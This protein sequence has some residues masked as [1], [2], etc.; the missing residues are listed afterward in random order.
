M[1]RHLGLLEPQC[2][3]LP[4]LPL[5]CAMECP[6]DAAPSYELLCSG[7]LVVLSNSAIG[8]GLI[9]AAATATPGTVAMPR[10][11]LGERALTKLRALGRCVQGATAPHRRHEQGLDCDSARP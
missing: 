1:P 3:A 2:T 6:L 8:Q 7:L 10:G 11:V 9:P 4:S 5:S